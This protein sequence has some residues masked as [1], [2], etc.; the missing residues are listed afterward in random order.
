MIERYLCVEGDPEFFSFLESNLG[1]SPSHVLLNFMLSGKQEGIPNLVRTHPGTASAQGSTVVQ[2]LT[3][4]DVISS[5]KPECVDLIK[6]DVDGYDGRVLSGAAQCLIHHKPGVIFEWHPIL[7]GRA[8]TS[9]L[10]H[11]RALVDA[12]YSRFAWFTKF[13][14]FSH[15]SNGTDV[16][17][18]N[19]LAAFCLSDEPG[20]WHYDV[21]A[22][23]RTSVIDE[24][25][26]AL[27]QHAKKRR[28]WY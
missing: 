15:F 18:I 2:A 17:A 22:L 3:L 1:N 13:G 21:V 14:D 24:T 26:L 10:E 12:G 7:C 16:D 5:V 6:V 11:F 9:W 23:H 25:Q 4:D 19:R 27:L 20:D 28:S 8:G